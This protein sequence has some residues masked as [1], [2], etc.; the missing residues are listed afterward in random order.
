MT[1]D[2]LD[3][4]IT[5]YGLAL[6]KIYRNG[7]K[8]GKSFI[9]P[10]EL[11]DICN[12]KNIALVTRDAEK[13][14]SDDAREAAI[15]I[16][17]QI[18]SYRSS[19]YVMENDTLSCTPE[20]EATIK[21]TYEET[22]VSH[23]HGTLPNP[24][25]ARDIFKA[26]KMNPPG[27]LTESLKDEKIGYPVQCQFCGRKFILAVTQ[28]QI[29]EWKAG[30]LAPRVFPNLTPDERELLISGMCGKCFDDTVPEEDGDPMDEDDIP[31]F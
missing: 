29:T 27:E 21:K 13:N 3:I 18:R 14:G 16:L 31:P 20:G 10:E 11:V 22:V 8:T 15:N 30:G 7:R 25:K 6:Q 5:V 9:T 17:E 28:K 2:Q 19:W 12:K 23:E 26:L 24:Q 1:D 4:L